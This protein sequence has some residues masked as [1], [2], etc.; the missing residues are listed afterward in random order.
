MN[1]TGTVIIFVIDNRRYKVA[2]IEEYPKITTP[3]ELFELFEQDT[4]TT[5][6]PG[7]AIYIAHNMATISHEGANIKIEY[8]NTDQ[9]VALTNE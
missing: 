5:T 6:S 4:K 3:D 2:Y 9:G 1:N 7:L 8:V